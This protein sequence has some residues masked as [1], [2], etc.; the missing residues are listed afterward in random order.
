MFL[1]CLSFFHMFVL[2]NF[3]CIILYLT[4]KLSSISW[5]FP[6][7]TEKFETF[8]VVNNWR[9][10]AKIEETGSV[11]TLW[12]WSAFFRLANAAL[13]KSNKRYTFRV[14]ICS[15]RSP[16]CPAAPYFGHY[17][18]NGWHSK[19]K[20]LKTK[21]LFW[22]FLLLLSHSKNKWAKYHMHI[23]LHIKCSLFLSYFNETSIFTTDFR[24]KTRKYQ[25]SWKSFQ[26]EPICSMRTEG[27]TDSKKL[28]VA[29][30]NVAKVSR[31]WINYKGT[32]CKTT[33]NPLTPNDHYSSC[34]APLTSKRCILYIYSTNIGTEYFKHGIYSSFISLQNAVGFIIL[35]YFVPVLFTFYIQSVPKFKKIIPAPKG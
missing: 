15:L 24:K 35:T 31:N 17:L 33:L 25:I 18:I 21:Y 20:I 30:P 10:E 27:Q 23:D 22:F 9:K 28:V 13:K 26:W 19:T 3:F 34:T 8:L 32:T 14:C 4:L 1:L 11:Q 29:F 7:E 6:N 2:D 12:R 16:V 5:I